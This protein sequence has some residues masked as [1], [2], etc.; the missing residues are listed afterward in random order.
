MKQNQFINFVK[1]TILALCFL[2]CIMLAS[3][4]AQRL[5]GDGRILI[6][7]PEAWI[8]EA[9]PWTIAC[10]IALKLSDTRILGRYR[11]R[12]FIPILVSLITTVWLV[13]QPV[14][15]SLDIFR[16]MWDG[17]LILHGV[18][19]YDYVPA[20]PH[21]FHLRTWPYWRIMG[22]K[23][24]PEAYPPLAQIYFGVI[25]LLTKGALF[26]YKALLIVNDLVSLFLFYAVLCKRR[27]AITQQGGKK[28]Q[29]DSCGTSKGAIRFS[30]LSCRLT[31]SDLWNFALFALF[32]PLLVESFGA[33]HVDVFAIP[34]VLL[35]WLFRLQNRFGWMG[36]AIAMATCIKLYPIVL[37]AALWDK[38]QVRGI[39]KSLIVFAV[40]AGIVCVPF[41]SAGTRLTE[42]VSHV[43]Q[44]G[45][46]GS[47][48]YILE[49][50]F[51]SVIDRYS[52]VFVIAAELVVWGFILFT[53]LYRL[54]TE[55]KVCLAG[56]TF[57]LASPV[58]HPWYLLT[59][60]PFAIVAKD[61]ATLWLAVTS[62]LTYD[63]VPLDMYIEY[64]PTYVF[65]LRR[66]IQGW[67]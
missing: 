8:F 6:H 62:H 36:F 21:L 38:Q 25:A 7:A 18:N 46:N 49:K 47:I 51:G 63:E 2:C 26:Q 55:Q 1:F 34:W 32:P 16:Y 48:E 33:G 13:S 41:L 58:V 19:P 22:W 28:S 65:F 23:N 57:I 15:Y 60:L 30:Y 40:S 43:S 66:F 17:R 35:A 61:I 5:Y 67:R 53:K 39:M 4:S 54:P 44:M 50:C 27:L 14:A 3:S 37:F 12:I 42:F 45:Y 24:W 20:N 11:L 52:T 31:N 59:L 29:L 56:L 9:L 64:L 10:L